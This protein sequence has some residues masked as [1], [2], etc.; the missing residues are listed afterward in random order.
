MNTSFDFQQITEKADCAIF[1]PQ[2]AFFSQWK[3]S[4]VWSMSSLSIRR[5]ADYC[6]LFFPRLKAFTPCEWQT[7]HKIRLCREKEKK[8][9]IHWKSLLE[10]TAARTFFPW[11]K[12]MKGN[13]FSLYWICK[14]G[15]SSNVSHICFFNQRLTTIY[16]FANRPQFPRIPALSTRKRNVEDHGCQVASEYHGLRKRWMMGL[17]E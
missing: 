7:R 17:S 16:W 6:I 9:E 5:R 3:I 14:K 1:L 11:W 4:L 13:S 2:C 12:N 8:S 10:I 15:Y